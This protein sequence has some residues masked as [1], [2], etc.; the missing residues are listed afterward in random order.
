MKA[1]SHAPDASGAIGVGVPLG[2]GSKDPTY[3]RP[4]VPRRL[5]ARIP[6]G[7][8]SILYLPLCSIVCLDLSV[9]FS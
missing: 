5:S 2:G 6:M 7:P 4:R 1:P 8:L 9:M 3:R